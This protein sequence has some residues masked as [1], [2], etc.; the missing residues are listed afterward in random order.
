MRFLVLG[1]INLDLT[2]KVDHIVERGETESSSSLTVNAGGKGANQAAAL[3]K[4]GADVSFAGKLGPDGKWVLKTLS[5]FD[6][7]TSLSIVDEDTRTGEAIIQVDKGGEN[8]IL[9]FAGGNKEFKESEI[10]SIIS[11]F[12]PGDV[13]VMQN[14][15]NLLDH[16]FKKAYERGL[17]IV[18]NPSPFVPS[19]LDLPLDKV[20]LFFVNEVEAKAMTGY[21]GDA[22]SDDDFVKMGK[23]LLELYPDGEV[24]LTAGKKGAYHFFGSSY[25]YSPIVDYPVLD[26]TGAGDTFTGYFLKARSSGLDP[27]TA[28]DISSIAS[29]LAVSRP[30]AMGAMPFWSEVMEVF[31]K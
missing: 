2:F 25:C 18:F 16:A 22:K 20:S 17:K 24:V 8:C 27:K 6:A 5:S 15:I 19:L 11:S 12:S 3:A 10:D 9:L 23:K 31:G 13:I 21:P 29:G 1:S 30:G 14:E 7:D 26:T 4:A 28:L